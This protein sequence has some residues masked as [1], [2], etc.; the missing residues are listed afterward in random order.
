MNVRPECAVPNRKHIAAPLQRTFRCS[1]L[2]QACD[3]WEHTVRAMLYVA[4][5]R[6]RIISGWIL[7]PINYYICIRLSL[8]LSFSLFLYL[9]LP[10][11]LS[12]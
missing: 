12:L 7:T 1:L 4:E 2:S 10:F 3:T 9:S 5:F 6:D 8:S 11:S